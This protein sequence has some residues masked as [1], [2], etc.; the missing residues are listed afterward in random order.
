MVEW[1][2]V[3]IKEKEREKE[4]LCVRV[5]IGEVQGLAAWEGIT[6]HMPVSMYGIEH[7]THSK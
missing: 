3:D 7:L 2:V 5:R 4:R 6:T 1:W